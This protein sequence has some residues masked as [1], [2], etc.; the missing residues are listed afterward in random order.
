MTFTEVNP[1]KKDAA[2]RRYIKF[3]IEMEN[4]RNLLVNKKEDK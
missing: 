2:I 3:L 1:E 4:K